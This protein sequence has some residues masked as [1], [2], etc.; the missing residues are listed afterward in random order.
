MSLLVNNQNAGLFK[1][2][3]NYLCQKLLMPDPS[4]SYMFKVN[5]RNTR[6]R[7]EICSKL[8]I[9]LT[10]YCYKVNTLLLTLNLIRTLF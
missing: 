3:V 9:K 8:T 7:C 4:G 1:S 6:T 5:N 10:L 2:Q